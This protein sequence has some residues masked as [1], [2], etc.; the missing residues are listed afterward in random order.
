M[1]FGLQTQPKSWLTGYTFW[2]NRYLEIVFSKIYTYSYIAALGGGG[3][4]DILTVVLCLCVQ[5]CPCKASVQN[6][7]QK[8]KSELKEIE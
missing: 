7:G 4:S 5:Y 8:P 1:V 3:G 6:R 2:V